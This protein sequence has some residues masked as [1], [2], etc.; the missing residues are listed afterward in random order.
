LFRA[1]GPPSSPE[2]RESLETSARDLVKIYGRI[3]K[4]LASPNVRGGIINPDFRFRTTLDAV[5]D[6]LNEM[7]RTERQAQVSVAA[8]YGTRVVLPGVQEATQNAARQE[9]TQN[10]ARW[11]A[12][13][14]PVGSPAQRVASQLA[15][16]PL[17]PIPIKD[18]DE[19][20]QV[21]NTELRKFESMT[22]AEQAA[23]RAS[24]RIKSGLKDLDIELSSGLN[25][26]LKE[27]GQPG[28]ENYEKRYASLSRFRE[29]LEKG[30]N[31]S[32]AMSWNQ[33]LHSFFSLHGI[34]VRGHL[35]MFESPGSLLEEGLS[36]L[37][38]A[39]LGEPEAA[40]ARPPRIFEG[41]A[42]PEGEALTTTP[43]RATEIPPGGPGGAPPK[44]PKYITIPPREK[45]LPYGERRVA[46]EE[47]RTEGA[48]R[49]KTLMKGVTTQYD[50][51]TPGE[52][53]A[54]DVRKARA[55][56]PH[57]ISE[58]DALKE[59]MKDPKKYEAY[60]NADQ[61]TRDRMLIEAKNELLR[62][63]RRKGLAPPPKVED[64]EF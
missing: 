21:V 44:T 52:K 6:Y 25:S 24:S 57:K 32:E 7:Y 63:G 27:V 30:M 37:R 1:F 26:K 22:G 15:I 38:R 14:L 2:F 23:L 20:A 49:R 42:V 16:D 54:E 43:P 3:D 55:G 56:E 47:P 39:G 51:P 50:L 46:P 59:I 18:I 4:Q 53:L 8:Q 13:N 64:L 34:N 11:L 60:R 19:F 29:A 5:K 45:M 17:R 31:K 41:E 58:G 61:K 35:G 28:L 33:R 62:S 36:A 48:E 10:T 12:R 40:L 9:V